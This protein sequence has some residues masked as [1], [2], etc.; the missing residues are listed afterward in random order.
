MSEELKPMEE[1]RAI[2]NSEEEKPEE[3]SNNH[4]A[5]VEEKKALGE[6]NIND[7]EFTIDKSKSYEEQTEDV[8]GAMA[9]AKAV[10][11]EAT[12]QDLA[13]KKAEELKAKASQKLKTAQTA[14]IK[15]ETQK[16]NYILL[17]Q[18]FLQLRRQ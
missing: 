2:A 15:A 13:D 18:V 7:I 9:T 14:D 10:S 4:I 5:T 12:A 6:V 17:S 1:L 8:V 11:D 3:N 16:Q